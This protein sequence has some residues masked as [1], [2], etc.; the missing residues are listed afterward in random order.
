MTS[1]ITDTKPCPRRE[2]ERGFVS[3]FGF[4]G[5]I[6]RAHFLLFVTLASDLPLRAMKFCSLRR[7]VELHDTL[8]KQNSLMRPSPIINKFRRLVLQIHTTIEM[9][10]TLDGPPSS[11][12]CQSPIL[13]EIVYFCLS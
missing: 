1:Q 4:N 10:M 7:N 3:V 11:Y 13:V 12:Q 9:L 5:T 6:S 2:A 8:H